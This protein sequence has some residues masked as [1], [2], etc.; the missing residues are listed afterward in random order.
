MFLKID[1]LKALGKFPQKTLVMEFAISN[2][3]G[4]PPAT[5][6]EANSTTSVFLEVFQNFHNSYSVECLRA[7][8]SVDILE[9][10]QVVNLVFS[11]MKLEIQ[12]TADLVTFTEE[13]LKVACAWL[14]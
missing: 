9:F 6:L 2:V 13:I 5:F 4:L 3:A 8:A 14:I 7:T 12:E 10:M 1:L 11:L